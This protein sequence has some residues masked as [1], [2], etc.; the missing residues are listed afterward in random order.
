MIFCKFKENEELKKNNAN[1]NRKNKKLNKDLK[2]ANKINEEVLS[3]NSWKITEPLRK[4][5]RM[6]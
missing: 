1:L 6:F 2:K 3:S 5:K 4:I